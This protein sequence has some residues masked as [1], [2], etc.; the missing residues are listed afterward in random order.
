M[1]LLEGNRGLVYLCERE[2]GMSETSARESDKCQDAYRSGILWLN[3]FY[4]RF[5]SA[6]K[7]ICSGE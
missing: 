4:C 2:E 3:G 6:Q 5:D 1:V 7:V